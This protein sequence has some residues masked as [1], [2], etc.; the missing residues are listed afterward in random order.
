M[1]CGHDMWTV[2]D[3]DKLVKYRQIID[4]IDIIDTMTSEM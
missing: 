4:F 3:V 2:A 1:I